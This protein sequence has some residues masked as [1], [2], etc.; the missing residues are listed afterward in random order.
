MAYFIVLPTLKPSYTCI[1]PPQQF[2]PLVRQISWRLS[3]W[4]LGFNISPNQITALS[5]LAGLAAAGGYALGAR[6]GAVAGAG[7]FIIAYILDNCDGEVARAK[8]L[9]SRWGA[10]F[11]TVTDATLHI[12]LFT[13]M[14]YGLMRITGES[15]WLWVGISATTGAAINSIIAVSRDL[16]TATGTPAAPGTSPAPEGISE[17]LLYGLRELGRADFCFLLAAA[18]LFE[19]HQWL[20]AASAIGA[21]AYWLMS[22]W[23][24]ANKFHV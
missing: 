9:S 1:E 18:T 7:L 16:R 20:L 3:N 14:G 21:Q 5:L 24:S 23:R 17:W 22:F 19:V 12:I 15:L 13:A 8:Q 11:D 2:L 6:T 4:L 10:I